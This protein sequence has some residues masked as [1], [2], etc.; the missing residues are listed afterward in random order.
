MENFEEFGARGS[1][2]KLLVADNDLESATLL[3]MDLAK[4][5]NQGRQAINESV[6]IRSQ[7]C[8]LRDERRRLGHDDTVAMN[9]L[10][11]AILDFVDTLL[12]PPAAQAPP[13]VLPGTVTSGTADASPARALTGPFTPIEVERNRFAERWRRT[14][15]RSDEPL[16][17]TRDVSRSFRR[18]EIKFQ[19]EPISLQVRTGAITAIVGTNG[20]GKTTLLRLI[21]GDIRPERGEVL[22]PALGDRSRSLYHIKSQIAYLPQELTEWMGPLVDTLHF[23]AAIHGLRGEENEI[24]TDFVLHR[25]ELERYRDATWS[26]ISGG[27]RMRFA[28]ANALIRRPRLLVL[29]EPLAN[30]DI[31]AQGR[32]LRDLRSYADS[33]A[34]PLGIVISSQHI[35]QVER[36]ADTI[37][38]LRDGT[39]V[40]HGPTRQFGEERAENVFEVECDGTKE[41]LRQALAALDFRQIS[42]DGY[43]FI[44][45][46][47]RHVSPAMVLGALGAAAVAVTSFRDIST[48]TRRIFLPDGAQP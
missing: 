14:T 22:Y 40:Y 44:I 18:N 29:D 47:D 23:T 9:R 26:Q 12:Q 8:Q 1:A 21:A 38:A 15:T 4:E 32:F 39:I 3:L 43:S 46:T 11:H 6:V 13:S 20:S 35:H 37:I 7:Y 34:W 28:L 48:S 31:N 41:L 2:V 24:E 10:K 42:T 27:Y 36:I 17:L 19:L 16:V 5:A 33:L 45:T 30:L 25:L